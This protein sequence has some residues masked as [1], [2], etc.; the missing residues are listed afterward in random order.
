MK[1][2]QLNSLLNSVFAHLEHLDS[3]SLKSGEGF[4][5]L[6]SE[7][8]KTELFKTYSKEELLPFL[9]QIPWEGG[10]LKVLWWFLKSQVDQEVLSKNKLGLLDLVPLAVYF[11]PYLFSENTNNRRSMIRLSG[12]LLYLLKGKPLR[13]LLELDPREWEAFLRKKNSE[14]LADA[15]KESGV[16]DFKNVT[17]PLIYQELREFKWSLLLELYGKFAHYQRA[18]LKE[19]RSFRAFMNESYQAENLAFFEWANDFQVFL[20]RESMVFTAVEVEKIQ[21][22]WHYQVAKKAALS[23]EKTYF[24]EVLLSEKTSNPHLFPMKLVAVE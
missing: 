19:Q 12:P 5:F 9:V 21:G 16:H 7:F 15:L 11:D 3:L 14:S 13:A 10:S 17:L 4:G 23:A 22:K 18:F 24:Y 20:G 2:V 8:G 6:D 1:E